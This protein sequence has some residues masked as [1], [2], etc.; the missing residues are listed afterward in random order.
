MREFQID[1]HPYR[2]HETRL[3]A[4][5]LIDDRYV[6][7]FSH[8]EF[9]W[10]VLESSIELRN[11]CEMSHPTYGQ[12]ENSSP[13]DEGSVRR[14]ITRSPMSYAEPFGHSST[15]LEHGLHGD[16]GISGI[17][18]EN[19]RPYAPFHRDSDKGQ[20]YSTTSSLFPSRGNT[21]MFLS[22]LFVIC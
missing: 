18:M 6:L 3:F 10:I 14:T 22:C 9:H 2:G 13:L 19:M 4:A 12:V 1:T 16:L 15:D 8:V 17:E 20:M 11:I 21:S 5:R 7:H